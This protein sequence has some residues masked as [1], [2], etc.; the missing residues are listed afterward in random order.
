MHYQ[1]RSAFLS[2]SLCRLGNSDSGAD[3]L[4]RCRRIPKTNH[5]D[6]EDPKEPIAKEA[7]A[8][9]EAI[10]QPCQEWQPKPASYVPSIAIPCNPRTFVVLEVF[11]VPRVFG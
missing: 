3:P 7:L 8:A 5:E 4:E 11:E 1:T 6:L 2:T 9:P 10:P